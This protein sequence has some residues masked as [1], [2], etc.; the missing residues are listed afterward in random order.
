M[1]ILIITLCYLACVVLAF[2]VVRVKITAVS[3]AVVALV[4]MFLL[5]GIVIGWNF[6]APMTQKMTVTRSVVP[7]GAS[8]NTKEVIKK[9]H[10]RMEQPVKKGDVLYEVERA[11]FQYGLDQ[12]TAQLA[13]ARQNI[14]ALEAA[15]VVA[16][17]RQ[18]VERT[19]RMIESQYE[20][21]DF[22]AVYLS[23]LA[24]HQ[25]QWASLRQQSPEIDDEAL[26]LS[27]AKGGASVLADVD[28]GIAA[29]RVLLAIEES[30]RT[31]QP[32]DLTTE[33]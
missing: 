4:G 9:V 17:R 22:P 2:K 20:R 21:D 13:E 14:L 7:L 31:G 23:L 27:I 28:D 33:E 8:F 18:G 26:G 25:A 11:P 32:V 19:A 12:S 5:G 24:I 3:I 10:V 16:L 30:V 15:V 6:S 1:I 29:T